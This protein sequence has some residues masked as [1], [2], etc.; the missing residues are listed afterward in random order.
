MEKFFTPNNKTEFVDWLLRISIGNHW[1]IVLE[2]STEEADTFFK[3]HVTEKA[4]PTVKSHYDQDCKRI[5]FSEFLLTNTFIN[6]IMTST[7]VLSVNDEKGMILLFADDY[8]EDCLSS[9]L[10]F[11][12]QYQKV[13]IENNLIAKP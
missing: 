7:H 5:A 9:T 13:L 3:R 11:F 6:Q 10:D 2:Y 8:H 4:L 12:S 1:T